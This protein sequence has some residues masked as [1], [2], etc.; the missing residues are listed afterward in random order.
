MSIRRNKR[1]INRLAQRRLIATAHFEAE[2]RTWDQITP[3][4][5]EFGSSDFER[6]MQEDIQRW[7]AKRLAQDRS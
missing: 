4:G 3:V 1:R 5:R 7:N 6:L 2:M